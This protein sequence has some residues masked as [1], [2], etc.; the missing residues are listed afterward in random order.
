M[1]ETPLLKIL[2]KMDEK[3][4]A[5]IFLAQSPK[6]WLP[7]CF[8]KLPAGQNKW[9][10]AYDSARFAPPEQKTT[11]MESQLF[12][13]FRTISISSRRKYR[14]QLETLEEGKNNI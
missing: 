11:V 2:S 7:G 4:K 13:L 6:C 5:V 12:L 14:E 9:A 8:V 10:W 3:V 1:N